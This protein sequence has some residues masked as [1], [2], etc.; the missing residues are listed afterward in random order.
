MPFVGSLVF[1]LSSLHLPSLQNTA[2]STH[3]QPVHVNTLSTLVHGSTQP[4]NGKKKVKIR[5]DLEVYD[6]H[7]YLM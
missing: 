6:D 4:L 7:L 3:V 5:S 1:I 2:A